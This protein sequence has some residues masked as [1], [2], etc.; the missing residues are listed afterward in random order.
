[1]VSPLAALIN[2]SC[3][4]NVAV[5]FP[6]SFGKDEPLVHVVAIQDIQPDTELF[7][8]Y[9]DVTLPRSQRHKELK[10]TYNF[11]CDCELCAH[12]SPTNS[13][14]T[15]TDFVDWRERIWCPNACGG[16]CPL[17]L[18]DDDVPKCVNCGA[19][20]KDIT[21]IIDVL[22]V[23]K[24]A[25]DKATSLQF[26]GTALNLSDSFASPDIEIIFRSR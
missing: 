11:V 5:V 26:P 6:R 9:I 22:R 1:M 15:L 19:Q 16:T 4:P 24:D 23:G 8:S 17:P 13:G 2:H 18:T 7:T 21:K 3:T 12:T 10:E 14:D 20:V 25:L